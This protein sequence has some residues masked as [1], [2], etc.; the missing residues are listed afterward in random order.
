MYF[1][2][3]TLAAVVDE[4]RETIVGG[5]VQR[6]RQTSD[7]SIAIEIYARGQRSH[8]LLSAHPQHARAHLTLERPS[9]GVEG[10]TRLLLLLRKYV[11]G[12]RIAGVEQPDLERVVILSIVK[13][14]AP[15]NTDLPPPRRQQATDN[16][17]QAS[18]YRS[19]ASVQNEAPTAP[20]P[21]LEPDDEPPDDEPPEGEE[22][23][24]CELIL[25]AMDRRSNIVLVGDDNIILESARHV[26]PRMS[27]RPVVPREP[28]ELPPRQ[29]KRDPRGATPEG[30]R[31]LLPD[32]EPGPRAPMLAG[33]LVGAYRGLSPQ[34]AREVVFRCTGAVDAPLGPD[35]PWARLALAL[36]ELWGGAWQPSLAL[37]ERGAPA[38]YAPYLLT[39][40]PRVEPQ[41]TIGAALETFYASRER[42]SS[43]QQR[44]D[45]LAGALGEARER[46]A[47]QRE[48]L[49]GELEQVQQLERLRWEGEMIL[50]FMHGLAPGQQE[51][52]VEGRAIA[53]DASRTPLENAQERFRAY[54]KA[55]G[56]LA[57]VPAR[58]QE[59]EARL[60]GLDEIVALLAIADGY[61]Q[62]EDIAREATGL[63]YLRP[64]AAPRPKVRRQSP[65]R[66][67]SSDG[68]TIYVGRSA[69]QNEQVTF[70]I[71]SS[72]DLWLHVRGIPGAHVIVKSG[73]REVPEQ[74]VLE[75]AALAAH[76]SGARHDVAAE[77]EVSRRRLVRRVPHGPPGLVSYRAERTVRVAPRAP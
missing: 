70:T 1:D 35:L 38:A 15:R 10:E 44:R 30:L 23:L 59:T 71:G 19:P 20:P 51:L 13:G 11:L 75:A 4:L 67:V 74:T 76:F 47:R 52:I 34:A 5:R 53:L 9:R 33:A 2:A 22:P 41:P 21:D 69:A 77:V 12:G 48:R 39:H 54:D 50:G 16:E 57:S 18:A 7:L 6:V 36:R 37:D 68:F 62:I 55:K 73:G 32:A 25:E 63:G 26:T 45:A 61:E 27:R 66:I 29:E 65:L 42:L 58:L 17:P 43:H 8:L 46:L 40:L 56:A 49:L 3:L 28:Y 14:P 24:R 31:A 64:A 60:A 72:D